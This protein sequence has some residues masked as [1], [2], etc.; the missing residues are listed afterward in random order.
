MPF[1]IK[2]NFENDEEWTVSIYFSEKQNFK[3]I[4]VYRLAADLVKGF[5]ID[6]RITAD[7]TN[8][9]TPQHKSSLNIDMEKVFR[10]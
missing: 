6:E 8:L 3:V 4:T 2:G 1:L 10:F 7:Q 9:K 5:Q